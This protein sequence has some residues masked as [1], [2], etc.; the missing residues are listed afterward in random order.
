MK[1]ASCELQGYDHVRSQFIQPGPRRTFKIK[2]LIF[3]IFFAVMCVE[4]LYR[5]MDAKFAIH[6][7]IEAKRPAAVDFSSDY[8][9]TYPAKEYKKHTTR[10]QMSTNGALQT[11]IV[12]VCLVLN[13]T[14]WLCRKEFRASQ[15]VIHYFIA[16]ILLVAYIPRRSFSF[17]ISTIKFFFTNMNIF[18]LQIVLG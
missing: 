7:V 13:N 3:T 16:A 1:V 9:I 11:G 2:L 4:N 12:F 8:D 6:H 18:V 17:S 15:H 10:M 5:Q 14:I